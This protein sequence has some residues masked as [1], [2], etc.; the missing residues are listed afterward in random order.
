MGGLTASPSFGGGWIAVSGSSKARV[1]GEGS[2][3]GSTE[4]GD[5][6]ASL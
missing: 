6:L 3:I 1:P 5:R 2:Y 4:G